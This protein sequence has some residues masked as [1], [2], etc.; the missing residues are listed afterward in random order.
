MG[1]TFP[2][3]GNDSPLCKIKPDKDD[4]YFKDK[5][6]WGTYIHGIFDNQEVIDAILRETKKMKE[7]YTPVDYTAYKEQHYDK[8]AEFVRRHTNM[9]LFYNI[10]QES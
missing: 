1:N 10:L 8:L 5:K 4:G 2:V 7:S 3:N 6:T 9:E